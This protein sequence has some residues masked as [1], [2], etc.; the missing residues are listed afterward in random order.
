[1]L[2]PAE[3]VQTARAVAP[4]AEVKDL[5]TQVTEPLP[6]EPGLGQRLATIDV[7]RVLV[8]LGKR[9]TV[10]YYRDPLDGRWLAE[11][12]IAGQRVRV[13]VAVGASSVVEALSLARQAAGL[14]EPNRPGQPSSL[15]AFGAEP[16]QDTATRG[17]RP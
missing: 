1:M 17:G 5:S 3:V 9:T 15:R 8:E 6:E 2:S 13:A 16:A 7:P 10:T 12:V 14:P 11:T 4:D